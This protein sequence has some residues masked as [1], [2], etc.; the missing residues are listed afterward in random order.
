ML[1][2]PTENSINAVV[3]LRKDCEEVY[4]LATSPARGTVRKFQTDSYGY[5]KIFIVWDRDHWRH[6]G[7]S[8]RWAYASHFMVIEEPE[9]P[10]EPYSSDA[11]EMLKATEAAA[12]IALRG[13]GFL[14]VSLERAD[15]G[16]LWPKVV[17]S[18]ISDEAESFIAEDL[19]PML[20][21]GQ[22]GEPDE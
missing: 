2:H 21:L 3:E 15:D 5:E 19:L 17:V 10:G 6:N 14:M 18:A 11:E 7:E 9:E 20:G 8:D 22:I 1:I 13:E 12:D 16:E 4:E